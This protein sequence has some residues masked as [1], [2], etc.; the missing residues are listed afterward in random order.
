MGSSKTTTRS[1]ETRN[2][3]APAI[4]GID[5]AITGIS[6]WMND[7][8]SKA[9]YGGPRTVGMS[10]MTRGGIADY[11]SAGGARTARDY[12]S[13]AAQGQY[14]GQGNPYQADLDQSVMASVMPGLNAQFSNSGM[15][16][17]TLHQ[18]M[19]G[20]AL[21]QGMAGSRYQNYQNERGMQQQAAM[22]LP[23]VDERIGQR[24]IE[25]GQI[26]EGY[27]R[28]QIAADQAKFN[29]QRMAG[30]LPYMTAS[31]L[32]QGLGSMGGTS[33][34]RQTTSTQQPLGQTLLGAGMM[35]A[36]LMSGNPMAAMG[37]MG[38]LSGA[39]GLIG[40][41]MTYQGLGNVAGYAP[42]LP[43]APRQY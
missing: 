27:G 10:D 26:G 7:P 12:L 33:T 5:S 2:P 21:A 39:G 32:L 19:M 24:A 43:W 14:V 28:E 29:E 37:G 9:V 22:A 36:S 40:N 3:Y 6:S 13:G 11:A 30:L 4:P 35:G 38:S 23:G 8:N 41:G 20:K 16:G 1:N 15:A 34:G 18:G 42:G 31:P 17:S 25:G